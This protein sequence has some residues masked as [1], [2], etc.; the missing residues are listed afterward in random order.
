M[1]LQ[2]WEK[3]ELDK[4]LLKVLVSYIKTGKEFTSKDLLNEL[5][6]YSVA[7]INASIKR[8]ANDWCNNFVIVNIS[9]NENK[10]Y[11][12]I[13]KTNLININWNFRRYEKDHSRIYFNSAHNFWFDFADKK[14]HTDS[15]CS[16]NPSDFNDKIYNLSNDSIGYF[17]MLPSI[18][19]YE[20]LFNYANNNLLNIF[21]I[22]ECDT[23]KKF[24]KMPKGFLNWKETNDKRGLYYNYLTEY[25]LI[26]SIGEGNILFLSSLDYYLSNC[27]KSLQ[28]LFKLNPNLWKTFNKI[29]IN[30]LKNLD[31]KSNVRNLLNQM[32][33]LNNRLCE[34]T[35]DSNRDIAYNLKLISAIADEE[36]NEKLQKLNFINNLT[37]ATGEYQVVV[38]QNQVEKQDEGRQQNNCVGYHYDNRIKSGTDYIYF[39]RRVSNPTKSNTTCRFNKGSRTTAEYRIKNNN[40]VTDAHVL[41]FIKVIDAIIKDHINE[42]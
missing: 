18:A 24:T 20:W 11:K 21:K 15:F 26:M 9:K 34:F 27:S 36:L 13:R 32:D 37:D 2:D 14:I 33:K 10:I 4:K 12:A 22:I 23:H 28:E 19:D 25:E 17:R 40:P 31:Y 7:N 39:I 6:D 30:S 29:A 5:S 16:E 41:D 38:P 1:A 42:L 8:Q 35:L 3:R